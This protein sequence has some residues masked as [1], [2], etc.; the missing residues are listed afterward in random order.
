MMSRPLLTGWSNVCQR[1]QEQCGQ[2]QHG[3]HDAQRNGKAK[4]LAGIAIIASS[5]LRP[6]FVASAAGSSFA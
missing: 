5:L 4:L 2:E 6:I 1:G 3:L